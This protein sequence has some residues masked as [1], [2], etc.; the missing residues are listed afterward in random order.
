MI[1]KAQEIRR[2]VAAKN[3]A[4]RNCFQAL[5]IPGIP[6]EVDLAESVILQAVI[7]RAPDGSYITDLRDP[8]YFAIDAATGIVFS[9]A[10]FTKSE[11]SGQMGYELWLPHYKHT[12]LETKMSVLK[13]HLTDLEITRLIKLNLTR[14]Q[15]QKLREAHGLF[16]LIHD[17]FYTNE[18]L[19]L[20]PH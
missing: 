5:N 16:H 1:I 20:Q 8:N 6:D 19:A 7:S 2:E 15:Y 14:T 11:L 13:L 9:G 3:P 12:R 17:D 10:P 18:G 4:M